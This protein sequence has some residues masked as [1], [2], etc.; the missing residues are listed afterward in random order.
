MDIRVSGHQVD[1]GSALKQHVEE[2]LDGIAEKYFS[3]AHSA[4]ATFGK[5]PHDHGFVCDIVAHIMQGVILKGAGQ[6]NDAHRAFDE[7]AE[8]IEKQVRRYKRRLRDH[9]TSNGNGAVQIDGGIE[10]GYT[11]FDAG[12]EEREVVDHPPVVAETRV[13][14]PESSVSDAVM[15]LDLRNTNAL[16]FRNAASGVYNMVYRRG[17]G[18][19]GWVEPPRD[20]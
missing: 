13:D 14:V 1:T 15:M 11:V 8:K 12:D 19:I 3:R 7:A 18:T 10:A 16:L 6:G 5:G 20:N 9:H 17:D 4:H 2:R